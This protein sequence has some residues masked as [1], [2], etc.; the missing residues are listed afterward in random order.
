MDREEHDRGGWRSVPWAKRFT[1]CEKRKKSL[2]RLSE[3][4]HHFVDGL[5]AFLLIE[6]I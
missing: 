5:P 3:N 4:I 1:N 2:L 6:I